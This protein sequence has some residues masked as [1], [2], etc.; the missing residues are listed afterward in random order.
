[1]PDYTQESVDALV[2]AAQDVLSAEAALGHATDALLIAAN[3]LKQVVPPVVNPPVQTRVAYLGASNFSNLAGTN[4]TCGRDYYGLASGNGF[5]PQA[6]LASAQADAKAGRLSMIS[7]GPGN[8][9]NQN[10]PDLNAFS[11]YYPALR[12]NPNTIFIPWHEPENDKSSPAV[13]ANYCKT[14]ITAAKQNCP[15]IKSAF[16]LMAYSTRQGGGAASWLSAL[17]MSVIDYAGFDSY[18]NAKDGTPAN[19]A[20][21]HN[22]SLAIARSLKKPLIIPE[23]GQDNNQGDPAKFWDNTVIWAQNN[24]DVYAI[25]WWPNK[26]PNGDHTPTPASKAAFGRALGQA[27]FGAV[28]AAAV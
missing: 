3:S 5:N 4:P 20:T 18:N 1:M 24:P 8:P 10:Q 11:A 28:K 21:F 16:C 27:P 12:A 23:T 13:W 9:A 6:A 19:P 26:G 22:S 2:K 14:L 25:A 7:V 15:N 17:D